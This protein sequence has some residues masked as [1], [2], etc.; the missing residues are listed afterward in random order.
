MSHDGADTGASLD[1][2]LLLETRNLTSGYGKMAVVQD[3]SLQVYKGDVML[4]AG[5]NGSGKSTLIKTLVGE[6]TLLNGQ[7]WFKHREIT[8]LETS[9]IVKLGMSY[10]PQVANVFD[11]LTVQDNLELGGYIL[12]DKGI[13]RQNMKDV[14]RLFEIL[15]EK[16]AIKAKLLSG[17]Q[18]QLLAIGRS[19]MTK[20]ILLLLDE[21]SASVAPIF[22]QRIFEKISEIR[23][24]GVTIVL[25]E[26]D[27]AAG[28]SIARRA[29]IL[30]SGRE[31][32]RT[33]DTRSINEE[34]IAEMV[35][36][37]YVDI[38]K[39]NGV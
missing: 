20:P 33:D 6:A 7:V 14:F 24:L 25:V 28:L 10:V 2:N 11:N 8:Q 9:E 37:K 13:L 12:R 34:L 3:V 4:I 26:Q 30:A 23:D 18:R 5:A 27:I 15:E 17:G 1:S 39:E 29:M 38:Q 21:P 36:G 22:V 19:L 32:F 35:L 16:R 31:V